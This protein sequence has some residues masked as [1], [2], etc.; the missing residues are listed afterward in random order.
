M[1][2]LG[3]TMLD[4]EIGAGGLEGMAAEGDFTFPHGLDVLRCPAVAERIGEVRPVVGEH[5]VDAVGNGCGEGSQEVAGDA[6][7]SFR[8][9]FDEGQ[10]GCTV[11]GDEEME[12][13]LC[14]S[15]MSMWK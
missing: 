1:M 8:V 4:A 2:G 13:A 11:D 6:A 3:Q 5:G 10:L 15:A 14:T 9:Q 12:L 7:G